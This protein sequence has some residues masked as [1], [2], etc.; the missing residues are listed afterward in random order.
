MDTTRMQEPPPAAKV[1]QEPGGAIGA[2]R[3]GRL[4]RRLVA[5]MV[6]WSL[7][8]VGGVV[9]MVPG[10]LLSGL[11]AEGSALYAVGYALA[12][13]G[14]VGA[15][16]GY[17]LACWRWLGARSV[18]QRALGLWVLRSDGARLSSRR[19]LGRELGLKLAPSALG[20]VWLAASALVA[21]SDPA[22]R[23]LHDRLADTV[24]VCER[25]PRCEALVG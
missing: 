4:R 12:V 23:G 14:F 18:G 9:A 21:R 22:R 1:E 17:W 24:V 7:V 11:A 3:V 5:W 13:L 6:D 10:G 2:P 16:P 15:V 20:G 19:M 8:L 25:P